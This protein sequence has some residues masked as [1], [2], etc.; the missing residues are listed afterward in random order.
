MI[1]V[2]YKLTDDTVHKNNHNIYSVKDAE[3]AM[4]LTRDWSDIHF[5]MS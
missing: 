1:Y 2:P 3:A 4:T 5:E